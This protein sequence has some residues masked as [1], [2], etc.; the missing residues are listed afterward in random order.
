MEKWAQNIIYV[1]PI[2]NIKKILMKH[3]FSK[4]YFRG[5]GFRN[6]GF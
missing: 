1:A 5:P 3:L 2:K 4:N 6:P